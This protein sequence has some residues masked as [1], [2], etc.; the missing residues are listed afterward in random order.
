MNTYLNVNIQLLWLPRMIKFVGFRRAR[1][2]TFEAICTVEPNPVDKP[3]TINNQ[4]KKT[5]ENV[6]TT[7]AECWHEMPCTS[8]AYHTALTKLPDGREHPTFAINSDAA[9]FSRTTY[10]TLYCVITG[11]AFTGEYT[12]CFY[13]QHTPEQ[14]TCPCGE[15]V[16]MVEHILL[17]CPTHAAAHQ[18]HLPANGCPQHLPHLFDYNRPRSACQ[19]VHV[20]GGTGP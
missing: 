17:N 14:V 3:H 20:S 16:Q 15:P 8:L 13:K 5:K 19:H 4:K 12:Q 6:I 2:L 10:C 9:K 1:Q 7:W 18:R 11:H